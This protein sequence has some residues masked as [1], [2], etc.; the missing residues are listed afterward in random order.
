[1]I[2]SV[3]G[4]T[5]EVNQHRARLVPGWV[6][7][8]RANHL[9]PRSTRPCIPPGLLNRVAVSAEVKARMSPLPGGR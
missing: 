9:Q 4:R 1:M 7:V 3:V 2:V 6:T 5:N 8:L